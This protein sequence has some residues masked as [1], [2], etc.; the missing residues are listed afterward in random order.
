[1]QERQVV[2]LHEVHAQNRCCR[3]CFARLSKP[4]CGNMFVLVSVA[5]GI[6][7]ARPW[8]RF[9][10]PRSTRPCR[11]AIYGVFELNR[12]GVRF[13]RAVSYDFRGCSGHA[14]TVSLV[15][16]AVTKTRDLAKIP[17]RQC[18]WPAKVDQQ[19]HPQT[20]RCSECGS[21][22]SLTLVLADL[23]RY[24]RARIHCE[25]EV[26]FEGDSRTRRDPTTTG[27]FLTNLDAPGRHRKTLR[28]ATKRHT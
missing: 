7:S 1:M 25:G 26:P 11:K 16:D 22:A 5:P 12:V 19:I 28:N 9:D 4:D 10:S 27:P 20:R 18:A 13:S 6:A 15:E 17:G 14:F 21:A 23:T 24:G 3:T 8:P 2:A